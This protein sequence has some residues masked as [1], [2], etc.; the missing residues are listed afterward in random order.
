[1]TAMNHSLTIESIYQPSQPGMAW[2]TMR[3]G[4]APPLDSFTGERSDL[5]EE[6][7]PMFIYPT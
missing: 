5:F 1:M 6:W 2:A 7:L 3:K 4:K